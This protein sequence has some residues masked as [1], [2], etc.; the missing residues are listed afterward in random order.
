LNLKK[1]KNMRTN[2]K[3]ILLSESFVKQKKIYLEN[4]ILK[5]ISSE[6]EILDFFSNYT[7]WNGIFAGCVVNLASRFHLGLELGL[8][9]VNSPEE[10]FFQTRGHRVAG[11]IF[12]AAEDEY[13]DDNCKVEG[14]RVE[15]K[16]MAWFMMNKMYEFFNKDISTRSVNSMMKQVVD[17]AKIGYGFQQES[18][19][20][21]LVRQLGFHIGSEKIASYEFGILA[22]KMKEIYPELTAWLENQEMIK[23]INAFSWIE[24]H[25]PVEDAHANYALDAAQMIID[26][27]GTRDETLQIK[28]IEELKGGFIDFINHQDGFFKNYINNLKVQNA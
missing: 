9:D 7:Y 4:D 23:G 14:V 16:T 2:I 12:A 11:L 8:Y 10:D 28:V 5:I 19:F 1:I 25:G 27:I 3:E 6:D 26:Y 15:H 13:S 20:I 17:E 18:E 24:V 21:N 22:E